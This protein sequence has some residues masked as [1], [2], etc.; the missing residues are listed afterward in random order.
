MVLLRQLR[1]DTNSRIKNISGGPRTSGYFLFWSLFQTQRSQISATVLL[2]E[3]HFLPPR[4]YSCHCI[5]Q[6]ATV[7]GLAERAQFTEVVF[8]SKP[9]SFPSLLL[10]ASF[11]CA[12]TSSKALPL[13]SRR[14]KRTVFKILSGVFLIIILKK[15]F[16]HWTFQVASHRGCAS[17]LEKRCFAHLNQTVNHNTPHLVRKFSKPASCMEKVQHCRSTNRVLSK[18]E[19]Y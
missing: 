8:G 9:E 12:G 18:P 6:L 3:L 5:S 16:N 4:I 19:T 15:N 14:W 1:P 13:Y 17:K 7:G 10:L 2:L 11:L